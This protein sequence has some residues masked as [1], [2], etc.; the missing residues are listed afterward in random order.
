MSSDPRY[1]ATFMYRLLT[2]S[3]RDTMAFP[4]TRGVTIVDWP[5]RLTER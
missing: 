4:A 1:M 3:P 5:S 2:G